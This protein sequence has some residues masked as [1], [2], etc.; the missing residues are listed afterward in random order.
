MLDALLA[1]EA[2]VFGLALIRIGTIVLLLPNIGQVFVPTTVRLW[3]AIGVTLLLAPVL[4]PRFPPLP[5]GL[6]LVLRYAVTE[7]IIG[8]LI[9]IFFRLAL[10][11]MST[12]GSII[13]YVIGLS[14][15]QLFNPLQADQSLLPSVFLVLLGTTLVFASELHHLLFRA[16]ADSYQLLPPGEALPLGDFSDLLAQALSGAFRIGMQLAMPFIVFSFL[17]YALLGVMTRLSPQIQVFFIVL[18]VQIVLGFVILW[19]SISAMGL[20]F[21]EYFSERVVMFVN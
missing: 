9:G 13:G 16:I 18:P 8:L 15:A 5:S 17:F 19:L 7:T 1:T 4:E 12:A 10:A 3:L 14:N 21:L 11:A 2:W 20:V 6:D